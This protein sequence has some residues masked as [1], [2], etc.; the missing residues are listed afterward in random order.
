VE[1]V[2]S[3]ALIKSNQLRSAKRRKNKTP[4]TLPW[5]FSLDQTLIDYAAVAF[6]FL[7]QPSRRNPTNPLANSGNAAGN[8]TCD[9]VLSVAIV[10]G[11]GMK[12]SPIVSV[13]VAPE[14][15]RSCMQ[16]SIAHSK[17]KFISKPKWTPEG[18][19]LDSKDSELPAVVS[20]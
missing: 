10:N 12:G 19:L 13:I 4:G 15:C 16:L 18:R 17:T 3:Q 11:G 5:G 7:R 2:S 20:N 6:R 8:G 9:T 1:G 14:S